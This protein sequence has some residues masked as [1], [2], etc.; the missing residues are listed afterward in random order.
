MANILSSRSWKTSKAFIA[1][2]NRETQVDYYTRMKATPEV[3]Q[4]AMLDSKPFGSECEKILCELFGFGPRTS[5]QNDGTFNG[6]KIEIKCARYWAGKDDC[7]WQHL[8]PEH[9]YEYA[10]FAVLDFAGWK[11]W[12]IKK[13]MLMG[14]LREKKVVT[15]QGKQGY[16]TRKSV[17]LPYLTPITSI[18]D[19]RDFTQ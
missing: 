6:K 5:T 2:K 15:F 19:L 11:V 9:D 1:M 4:L 12:G 10:L 16:W 8:E 17:I 14:E 13:S 18:S 7:V 3:L